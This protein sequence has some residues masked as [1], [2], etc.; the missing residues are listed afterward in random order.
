M[1]KCAHVQPKSD[2]LQDRHLSSRCR[3]LD[4]A[5]ES[6]PDEGRLSPYLNQNASNTVNIMPLIKSQPELSATKTARTSYRRIAVLAGALAAGVLPVQAQ[7]ITVPNSSFESPAAPSSYPYV[8]IAIDS[9]QK[10][11]EPAFYTPAFGGYG[12][13]WVGTAGVFLDVNPYLNH[14]GS[15]AGYLLAVPQVALFQD[16]NSSATHDFNAT[17]E[18]GKAYNLTI[19]IFGKSSL[20][21]GSTLELSLYY[22]DGSDNRVTVG[23]TLVSYSA[24]AFPAT[25]LNFIDYVVNVP[26]VQAGDAWA[27]QHIGIQL[28]ST[29]PIELTS[30]GNWDFDKVRLTAVPEPGSLSLLLVGLGGVLL[31][32]GR[33]R[34][35]S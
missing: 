27:G 35:P 13:P 10:N 24:A 22:R 34:R 15:Q 14:D 25:P 19:G 29:I 30:F 21:A 9:W 8:N 3:F 33:F 28:A 18:V 31:A 4:G 20:T 5:Q 7:P 32:R 6:H 26:T 1:H 11:P 16:Y 2:Q 17:F 23:S 12:I